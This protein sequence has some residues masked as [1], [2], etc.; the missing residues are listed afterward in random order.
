MYPD[1]IIIPPTQPHT[2]TILLL[3]GLGSNGAKFGYELLS[4]SSLQ[5][6]F[7]STKFIFPTAKKR[8]STA[9]KR[10][11][12]NQWFDIASLPDK[13]YREELQLDGVRE[14]AEFIHS[15]IAAEMQAG[16]LPGNIVVGG[17]SQGCAMALMVMLTSDVRLGAVVGM[18]GWLPFRGRMEDV[19]LDNGEDDDGGCLEKDN[20]SLPIQTLEFLRG[21]LDMESSGGCCLETP[22]FLGHGEKDEKVSWELGFEAGKMLGLLGVDVTWK[23]YED[24]GHWYKVPDE[25]D[26]VVAFLRE[27]TDLK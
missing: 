22:V 4:S 1:P 16:V 15:L 14:S 23:V 6:L 20:K 13:S 11:P 25:I 21:Y 27:K 24:F 10:I 17:L 9:I 2:H 8:R 12:I 26:D 19:L 5:T 18:S 7:P 3:H